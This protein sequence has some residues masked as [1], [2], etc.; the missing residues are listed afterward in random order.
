MR[1]KKSQ[2][3]Q[4]MM[5]TRCKRAAQAPAL[6]VRNALEK[7]TFVRCCCSADD[8]AG[9]R[10]EDMPS[11]IAFPSLSLSAPATFPSLSKEERSALNLNFRIARTEKRST[12]AAFCAKTAKG[13]KDGMHFGRES[14]RISGYASVPKSSHGCVSIPFSLTVW[15][16]SSVRSL[17]LS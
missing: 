10:Y 4:A 15:F 3:E 6:W 17:H 12:D 1:R 14:V 2:A 9:E 7:G 11:P 16:S 13:R 5:S 8:S